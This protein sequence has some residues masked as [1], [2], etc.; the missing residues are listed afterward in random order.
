MEDKMTLK[1]LE[2]W[3]KTATN[4]QLFNMLDFYARHN[5]GSLKYYEVV[6]EI[7]GRMKEDAHD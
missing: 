7:R 2:A 1:E 3:L 4:D 6:A 5:V